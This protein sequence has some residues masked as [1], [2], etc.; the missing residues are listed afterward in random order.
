MTVC[1]NRPEFADL[2]RFPAA[3]STC[4]GSYEEIARK[5]PFDVATYVVIVTHGHLHDLECVRA[6]LKR[7]YR[8]AGFIGSVRKT[9]LLLE[10]AKND[11][12][13]RVKGEGL[14]AP[15]GLDINA[16]TPEELAVTIVGELIAV[17][18]NALSLAEVSLAR[19]TRGPAPK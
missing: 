13:D 16:E 15:I 12:F 6:V 8:H 19:R 3:V 4:F 10:Q 7:N 5:F 9:W 1:D 2:K 14:F 17:R 11:G 18:R